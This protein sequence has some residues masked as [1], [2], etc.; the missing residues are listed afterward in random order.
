[1][2]VS[3][4]C[5][6]LISRRYGSLVLPLTIWITHAGQNFSGTAQPAIVAGAFDAPGD[7]GWVYNWQTL[8]GAIVALVAGVLAYLAVRRQTNAQIRDATDRRLRIARSYRAVLNQDLSS[9]WD[10]TKQCADVARSALE[11]LQAEKRDFLHRRQRDHFRCPELQ[12]QV[13]DHLRQLIENLDDHNATQVADL[14]GCYQIQRA[15]LTDVLDYF[16][17]PEGRRDGVRR[18]LTT[19]NV[20]STFEQTV[21]LRMRASGMFDFARRKSEV[22][23]SKFTSDD[24]TSAMRTLDIFD[25]LSQEYRDLLVRILCR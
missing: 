6:N 3:F 11:T 12:S 7:A 21:A 1:M 23:S 13:S 18:I 19:D 4:T 5:C 2:Q 10:Y 17:Y 8:I 20:E 14:V 9:I 25:V 24:V 22:I 15:R 16:N